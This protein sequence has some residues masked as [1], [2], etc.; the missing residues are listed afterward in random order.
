MSELV[1]WYLGALLLCYATGW[2]IGSLHRFIRRLMLG[3]ADLS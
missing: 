1:A 2:G 3:A